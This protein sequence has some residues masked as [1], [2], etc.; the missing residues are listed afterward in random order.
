MT[1]ITATRGYKELRGLYNMDDNEGDLW[2]NTK[3]WW[4]CVTEV[5]YHNNLAMPPEWLHEDSPLHDDTYLDEDLAWPESELA[6]LYRD[7]RVTM[8]DLLTF[9]RVLTKYLELLRAAG[10][11]E[12]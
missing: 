12:Q 4:F 8:Q 6:D 9:G 1:A 3:E 2:G 10:M 5:M 11:E 7:K